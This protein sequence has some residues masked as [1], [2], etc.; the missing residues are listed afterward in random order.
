MTGIMI[1]TAGESTR[2]QALRVPGLERRGAVRGP[3]EARRRS[4]CSSM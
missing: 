3:E 2:N 4:G 1:R